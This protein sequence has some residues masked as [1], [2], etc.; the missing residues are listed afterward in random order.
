MLLPGGVL[1]WTA[2]TCRV[3]T[4]RGHVRALQIRTLPASA[5]AYKGPLKWH[6]CRAPIRT[7]KSRLIFLGN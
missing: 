1:P 2:A 6:K 4:K 5:P 3:L 7:V